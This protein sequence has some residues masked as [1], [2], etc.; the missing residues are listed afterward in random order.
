MEKKI[1]IST[2]YDKYK[3]VTVGP[4][5]KEGYSKISRSYKNLGETDENQLVHSYRKSAQNNLA[6][7]Y[8]I[9]YDKKKY[10]RDKTSDADKTFNAKTYKDTKILDNTKYYRKEIQVS[11]ADNKRGLAESK[12]TKSTDVINKTTNIN[13]DYKKKDLKDMRFNSDVNIFKDNKISNRNKHNVPQKG[14]NVDLYNRTN[15][16]RRVKSKTLDK[17]FINKSMND[18]IKGKTVNRKGN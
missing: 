12:W 16:D 4:K 15:E 5:E 17:S 3:K 10:Q 18:N 9:Q 13:K 7:K 14:D 1:E 6:Q 11:P 8:E 2:K